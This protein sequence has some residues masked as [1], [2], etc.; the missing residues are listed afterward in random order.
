MKFF[1][2]LNISLQKEHTKIS[3]KVEIF[4]LQCYGIIF[5]NILVIIME[6]ANISNIE[7]NYIIYLL[8]HIKKEILNV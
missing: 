2:G 1:K 5:Y 7:L 8:I 3:K 4:I 6:N